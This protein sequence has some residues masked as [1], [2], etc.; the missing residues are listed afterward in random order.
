VTVDALATGARLDAEPRSLVGRHPVT[1]LFIVAFLTYATLAIATGNYLYTAD[2]DARFYNAQYAVRHLPFILDLW[3]KPVLTGLAAGVIALGGDV[4][5]V[6]VLQGFLA[7]LALALVADAAR[8]S[9]APT[10]DAVAAAALAGLSPFWVR[11]VFSVLT[12]ISCAVLLAAALNLWSRR[13]YALAALAVSFSFLARFEGFFFALALLPFLARKRSWLGIAF[14]AAGPI[15]WN[16]AGWATTG[17]PAF[18][19]TNEPHDL[20]LAPRFLFWWLMLAMLPIAA[21]ILL[22]P[23]LARPRRVPGPALAIAGVTLLLHSIVWTFGFMDSGGRPRYLVTI[24]PAL[25]FAAAF[26]LALFGRRGRA[27]LFGVAIVLAATVAVYRP[28][29]WF[30]SLDLARTPGALTSSPTVK[31][32]T[33]ANGITTWREAPPGTLIAWESGWAPG[34]AF[35]EIPSERLTLLQE[36]RQPKRW[37]WERDWV[38]RIYRLN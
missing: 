24:I 18:L 13:R 25:A 30:G 2:S 23:A 26:G 5:A 38:G 9:G 28:N 34:G 27:I 10:R 16:L 35:D 7:A 36:F 22:V 3:N 33:D 11:L 12:E 32:L 6:K 37:P 17:A 21:G 29:S 31:R 15:V 14:L 1:I 20:S 8:R 4:G 19:L